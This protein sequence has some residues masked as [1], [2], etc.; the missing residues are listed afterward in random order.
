MKLQSIEAARGVAALMVV[1]FHAERALSL[2]QYVGH[3]PLGGAT[4]F[5]HP[6]RRMR[7]TLVCGWV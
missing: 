5:M 2:P 7:S 1:A 3:M 6:H 4:V